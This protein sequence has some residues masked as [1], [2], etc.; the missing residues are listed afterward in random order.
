MC[1]IVAAVG[2][3]DDRLVP[4]ML[5]RIRHRG[6]DG[7][8][9]LYVNQTVLGHVRLAILDLATGVQ[10]MANEEGDL[11][12][13]FNGEIYNHLELRSR[14]QKRHVFKTRSDTEVL[15]HMYEEEGEDMLS[16]LD[17]M[18]AFVLAGPKGVLLARDTIGIKPLYYGTTGDTFIAASELKA[19]RS[20]MGRRATLLSPQAS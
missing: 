20:T 18:F 4:E 12:V 3:S 9:V 16:R 19:F 1:G 11:A 2:T 17:G 13:A 8:G 7:Q 10:P 5:A 6:P 14:I 15:L